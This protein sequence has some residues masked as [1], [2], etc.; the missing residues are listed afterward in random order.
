M[1]YVTNIIKLIRANPSQPS[2][3]TVAVTKFLRL[4]LVHSTPLEMR[5]QWQL[6][7]CSG[8]RKMFKSR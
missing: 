1:K 4:A 5:H 6:K 2:F 3:A 8:G 7:V